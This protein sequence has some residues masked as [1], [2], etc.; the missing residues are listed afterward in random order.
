MRKLSVIIPAFNEQSRIQFTLDDVFNFLK[1]QAYQSEVIVV[2]DASSDA[3]TN[4]IKNITYPKHKIDLKILQHAYNK[5]K[6]AAVKTGMLAATGDYTLFMD[7]D[8]ST[9]ISE[10]K[11]FMP[12]LKDSEIIIGSRYSDSNS[13]KIKQPLSRQIMSRVG[14]QLIRLVL[15][16]NYV[17]KQCGFK[18]F[19]KDA[20]EDIFNRTTINRWGFDMEILVIAKE[21]GYSIKELPVDW[22]NSPESQLRAGRAATETFKELLKIKNNLNKG[23]YK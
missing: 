22:Y 23:L 11:K 16:L 20:A 3:T 12:Y 9:K 17:D 19:T 2:D 1:N 6:G 4:V 7:A 15:K 18:L 21:L 14:N 5:G 10:I 13:V 8:N